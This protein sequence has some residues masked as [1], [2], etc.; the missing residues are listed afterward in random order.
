ML[1]HYRLD[2]P[3]FPYLR[4]LFPILFKNKRLSNFQ[5]EVCQMEKHTR[6]VFPAKP[7]RPSN[8]FT[9]I[10]S[11]LWG[12]SQ[13]TNLIGAKWFITFIDDHS[14]ICWVYLLKEKSEVFQTFKNSYS[15]IKNYFQTSIKILRTDNGSEYINVVIRLFI[16]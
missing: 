8:P 1:W 10:H 13:V 14:R 3:S 2:H 11:N 9:L 15:M 4:F 7:Y 5:C 16:N 6:L 12:P